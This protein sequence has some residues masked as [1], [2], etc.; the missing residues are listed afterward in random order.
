M[1]SKMKGNQAPDG[2]ALALGAV[3]AAIAAADPCKLVRRAVSRK[4]KILQVCGLRKDISSFDRILVVGGGKA[5]GAMAEELEKIVPV[6]EGAVAILQGTASRFKTKNIALLEAGHPRPDEGSVRAAERIMQLARSA[7]PSDLVFCLISG[8]GSALL[9]LPAP[10]ISVD[11]KADL[12]LALMTRGA[13][14]NELN[15]VRRHFSLIKGGGLARALSG[16]GRTY[17]LIISDVVG[18]DLASI[19]SGPTAADPST[20]ADAANVLRK[21]KLWEEGK[22]HNARAILEAG[23]R[24]KREETLKRMPA[25]V[26][27][28]PGGLHN[29]IIGSNSTAVLAACR[30]LSARKVEVRA[31]TEVAGEARAVGPKLAALLAKGDSFCAGGET[32]VTVKGKGRGGR[33]QE[34]ALS[35]ALKIAGKTVVLVSA[36]TDGIDGSSPAAGAIVDGETLGRAKKMKL[37]ARAYLNDNDSNSFF[38]KLGDEILTGP[39]G[40]NVNDI[41]IGLAL[42]QP[43]SKPRNR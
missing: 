18:N 37:D 1:K 32:T 16:A 21:Y 41:M 39:T 43:K 15:A 8:G 29:F 31:I 14:I 27:G 19:A 5:S 10:G 11:E 25:L 24:G 35:A 4:G 23:L 22:W 20:F 6:S 2:R 28:L 33:N 36:G 30:Y 9:S 38:K 13:N 17:S 34:L 7:G 40:T 12:A 3:R 26:H 42:G